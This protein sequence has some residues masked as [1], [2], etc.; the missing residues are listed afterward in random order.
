MIT[1]VIIEDEQRN[2]QLLKKITGA[3]CTGLV[4]LLGHAQSIND[5][6]ALIKCTAP[7]LVYLDIEINQGNAFELLDK[8]GNINFQVIFIT[9]FNEYAVKA[10]R[11]NAVDYLLKPINIAEFREATEKAIKRKDAGEN[12]SHI[13]EAIKQLKVTFGTSKIGLP[14]LDGVIF[15]DI[16]EIVKAE[17]CG[18]YSQIYLSNGE[19]MTVTKNLKEIELL[20]PETSFLRAHNSWIVNTKYLRKYYR[21][22][23]GYMEM[24]D[25]SIVPVSLRKKRSFLDFFNE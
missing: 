2:I 10:F 7:E 17:A 14:V 19:K 25:G 4:T 21:G 12:N 16:G 5:A 18:S 22:K 6:V 15:I 20:L 23:N 9:A 13:L 1:A 11:Y 3:Y 8:I 24:V